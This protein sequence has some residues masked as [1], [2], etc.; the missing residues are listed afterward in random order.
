VT[1]L[2][3]LG[4]SIGRLP[5]GPV[6]AIT[7]VSGVLVGHATVIADSPVAARTG[8]TMV[9]PRDHEIWTNHAFC[10]WHSFN[11]HGEMTGIP[12]IEESG[13]LASAVG[14]TN[15]YQVGLVRD[16]LVR[17]GVEA[18]LVDAFHL[19]VV[20][21]TDDG[22]LSDAESF[23]LTE[24]HVR[25]AIAEA[26][27]GAVAEGNVGGG[28]GM[29]CHEFK[30]GI[31]TS[32]RVVDLPMHTYTVGV[33]VQANYGSRRD[34]RIDGVPVGRAMSYDRVPPP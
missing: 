7:D 4:I 26:A 18:G 25:Q 24:S 22:W 16:T 33:L 5:T 19:P 15:T 21:E 30:G 20:A 2:R 3:D 13:L 34:L 29:V 27:G 32:S 8:V 31:G 9:I 1:R 28:T 12:W 17:V 14:I 10:G 23:V 11:G 6:N